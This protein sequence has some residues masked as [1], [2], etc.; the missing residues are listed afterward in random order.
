MIIDKRSEVMLGSMLQVGFIEA[1]MQV[2]GDMLLIV[3]KMNDGG[4]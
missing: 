1:D 2:G 4:G 3:V